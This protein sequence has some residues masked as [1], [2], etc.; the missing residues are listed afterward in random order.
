MSDD[1]LLKPMAFEAEEADQGQEEVTTEQPVVAVEEPA[2]AEKQEDQTVPLA[3]LQQVREEN[4]SLKQR[5]AEIDQIKAMLA[6]QQPQPKRPDLLDDPDGFANSV[7]QRLAGIQANFYAEL[8]ER[9]ARREHGAEFVDAAF[10]AAS[11]KGMIDQFKGRKDPWGDLARWHKAQQALSQIGDDPA[12]FKA[13][14]EAEI[15]AQVMAEVA[16][17]SVKIPAVSPSLAGQPNLG[18]RAAPE[19]GGPTPLDEILGNKSHY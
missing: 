4:R 12:A 5:L 2:K 19:W 13:R 7:E 18:S 8:S 1:D 14:L 6:A 3:A 9:E 11:D 10:Q 16:A 17:Q 15:R